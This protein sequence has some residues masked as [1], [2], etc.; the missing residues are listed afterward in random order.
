MSSKPTSDASSCVAAFDAAGRDTHKAWT[1]TALLGQVNQ[2]RVIEAQQALGSADAAAIS[3]LLVDLVGQTFEGYE[4]RTEGA[5]PATKMKAMAGI[6]LKLMSV[7]VLKD[8]CREPLEVVERLLQAA[9]T[10]IECGSVERQPNGQKHIDQLV[11]IAALMGD[12]PRLRLA[13][14]APFSPALMG[15]SVV[16]R[17]SQSSYPF[18]EAS[19]P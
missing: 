4:V 10:W 15:C 2:A 5:L 11:H 18:R 17:A 3:A 16:L 1:Q 8:G 6:V 9:R 19:K 14:L 12:D 7:H 13:L